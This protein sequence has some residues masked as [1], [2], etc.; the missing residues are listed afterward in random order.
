MSAVMRGPRPQGSARTVLPRDPF[1]T[2][3]GAIAVAEALTFLIASLLHQGTHI[4]VLNITGE[5][6]PGAVIPEAVIG[7]VMLA[8]AVTVLAAPRRAWG[9]ALGTHVFAAVGTAFGISVVLGGGANHPASDLIYHFTIEA[10]LL[11]M[12]AVLARGRSRAALR[13]PG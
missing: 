13:P 6:F 3:A 12:I 10:V 4:P 11:V 2:A 5:K 8:G 7:F 9:I 1:A